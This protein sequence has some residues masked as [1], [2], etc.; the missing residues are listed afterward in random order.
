MET[1]S[2][3]FYSPNCKNFVTLSAGIDY[4]IFPNEIRIYRFENNHWRQAWL[5]EPSV[6]PAT[7]EPEEVSW[8][9]NSIL[10]LKKRVWTGQ[11][12]GNIFA[13]STLTIR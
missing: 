3:P 2:R 5:L 6:E 7:L 1:F 13:Y 8:L 4:P 11:N 10:L 9:S 12:P